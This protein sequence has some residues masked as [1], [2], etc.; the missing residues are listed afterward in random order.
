MYLRIQTKHRGFSLVE[1]LVAM[2]L[3]LL[4]IAG[5]ITSFAGNKRSND[6]NT[7][8]AN[9]QENA[10]YAMNKISADVRSAG[11]QGCVDVNNGTTVIYAN[12]APT[13]KLR[14]TA[15]TG[16]IVGDNDIWSPAA[17]I[18]FNPPD[19]DTTRAIKGTQTLALQFGTDVKPLRQAMSGPA[20]SIQFDGSF[21]SGISAGD[22]MVIIADCDLSTLFRV[23][24]SSNLGSA[25]TN[26]TRLHH[27]ATHN[28]DETAGTANLVKSYGDTPEKL[29]QTMVM[30]FASD[31]Y[32]IGATSLTND[33]GDPIT[34]LYKQS[35]PYTVANP[36]T[37]MVQGVENMR[38]SF[39]I[40]ENNGTLRYVT[41][42][43]AE[44]EA[45][46]VE[47]IQVGLLMV[48]WESISSQD[49]ENTYV[50]AGQEIHASADSDDASTHPT[51][52]RLRLAFNTT[53]N[54]RNRRDETI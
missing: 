29:S 17:P 54:V 24:S 14:D 51:D 40:R 43:H 46:R 41:A 31:I 19:T 21:A 20:D 26:F 15:T 23:S 34:S 5:M 12:N 49:D 3:G 32:Y 7:A 44:Y 30:K 4:V 33:D 37:E 11:F 6:L 39:G 42:D 1:M 2:T 16:S 47:S 9:I 27:G 48:S 18:G 10:R 52:R 28:T 38:V 53:I 25:P 35:L 22:D 36:P 8:M 45:S 13:V 50:L